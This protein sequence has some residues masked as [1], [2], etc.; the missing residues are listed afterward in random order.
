[1]WSGWKSW[2]WTNWY[3]PVTFDDD[4]ARGIPAITV[5]V[6]GAAEAAGA[7]EAP[8]AALAVAGRADGAAE[9]PAAALAV[10]GRADGAT[11]A[12]VDGAVEAPPAGALD[13][14]AE[15]AVDAAGAARS[16]PHAAR[17]GSAARPAPTSPRRRKNCRR[18]T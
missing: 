15:G 18:L 13:G 17:I 7:A 2:F 5:G 6:G 4:F 16:V 14:A 12:P 3:L 11:E 9:A 8:A 1:M 10:A